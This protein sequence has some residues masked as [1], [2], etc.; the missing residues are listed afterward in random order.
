MHNLN[1]RFF[2]ENINVETEFYLSFSLNML[3][4]NFR[5]INDVT[6]F[7]SYVIPDDFIH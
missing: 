2:D 7:G 3:S 6:I 1:S 4:M 5:W